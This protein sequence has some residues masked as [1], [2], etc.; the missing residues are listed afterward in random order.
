MR[1]DADFSDKIAPVCT[2]FHSHYTEMEAPMVTGKGS[3]AICL[4]GSCKPVLLWVL[5]INS[6]NRVA[7]PQ[8]RTSVVSHV[9]LGLDRRT[10]CFSLGRHGL[11]RLWDETEKARAWR[12]GFLVVTE[13]G[14]SGFGSP[15]FDSY[16]PEPWHDQ[17]HL[18]HTLFSSSPAVQL[19]DVV[20]CTVTCM[21]LRFYKMWDGHQSHGQGS[22]ALCSSSVWN[23]SAN[24]LLTNMREI[25]IYFTQI[26]LV[27]NTPSIICI[28]KHIKRASRIYML[29][30]KY[31]SEL[32]PADFLDVSSPR[33]SNGSVL[34]TI[35]QPWG[36][37][38]TSQ[39]RM[40]VFIYLY[41][42][43]YL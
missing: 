7:V 28:N 11:G 13:G 14:C 15:V 42:E 10:V 27:W 8:G 2:P 21:T 25:G 16:S 34:I 26:R 33:E 24:S 32:F 39:E 3:S 30:L 6:S 4:P 29:I 22:S 1:K 18:H 41:I 20:N 17:V 43:I 19:E 31:L 40:C 35:V 23:F 9:M 36:H 12:P 5:R 37:I 38:Y